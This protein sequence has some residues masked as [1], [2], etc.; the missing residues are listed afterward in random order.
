MNESELGPFLE[1]WAYMKAI[2][3]TLR[4]SAIGD[5]YSKEFK[6]NWDDQRKDVRA[7][8]ASDASIVQHLAKFDQLLSDQPQKLP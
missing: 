1:L 6:Q 2:D 7:Q 8:L 5:Y 4:N 3:E